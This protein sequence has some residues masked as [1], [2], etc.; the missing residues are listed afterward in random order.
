MGMNE[1][2]KR[3]EAF[4]RKF[5][6]EESMR[7]KTIA[8]RNRLMGLWAAQRLGKSL[9]AAEAYANTVVIADFEEPG[10]EGVIRKVLTDF[11]AAGVP[12]DADEVRRVLEEF[13]VRAIDKIKAGL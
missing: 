3:W 4:E 8:R 11:E 2:T 10:G 6:H 13:M 5:A 9:A 1:L 12:S 7:F